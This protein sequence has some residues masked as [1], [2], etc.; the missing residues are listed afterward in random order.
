LRRFGDT[1]TVKGYRVTIDGRDLTEDLVPVSMT[2]PVALL[3]RGVANEVTL[4]PAVR[5]VLRTAG[6]SVTEFRLTVTT[7]GALH[8]ACPYPARTHQ[9]ELEEL[10]SVRT[11]AIGLD[12]KSV[13]E[14]TSQA[15]AK[16]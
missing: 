6:P 13:S 11:E 7:T 1:L 14:A 8:P 12:G 2:G 5:Y 16:A 15:R 9:E 4:I 3:R 10:R